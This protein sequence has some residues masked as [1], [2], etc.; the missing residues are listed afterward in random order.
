MRQDP[1]GATL[2]GI[3]DYDTLLP[4]D[5]PIGFLERSAWLRDFDQRLVA[6]VPWEELPTEH[7]VDFALLRSKL[8]FRRAEIEEI[9]THQKNPALY[10]ETALR[11]VFLLLARPFAP[12]EERKEPVLARLMALPEYLDAA[13]ANLQRVPAV[14]RDIAS[15]V[16]TGGLQFVDEVLRT[17]TRSFPGEAERIEHAGARARV[18]LIRYQEFLDRD[19]TGKIGGS[20]AIGER[21]MNYRLE[22]E[23]LLSMDCAYLEQ[24]GRDSMDHI[25]GQLVEEA[26]R[27]EPE[28]DW[29]ELVGNA[30]RRHP[31]ALRVRDAYVSEMERARRFVQEKR[32][33]PFAEG[34]L[35]IVD[36]PAFERATIPIASYLPPAPFD[37]EQAGTFFVTPIDLSRRREDVDSMLHSHNYCAITLASLH[38]AYPGHHLQFTHAAH[39]G[40]RLRR[41]ADSPVMAEGWALYCE[42]MMYEQGFFLDPLTRLYQLRDL[43]WRACRVVIDVGLHS[44][45]MS[46][47]QAVDFL[48][49]NAL[50]ER[51]SA[52]TEVKRYALTPTVPLSFLVGRAMLLDLREEAKRRL[53]SRFVLHDFHAQ[54]LRSGTVPPFFVREELFERLGA[55]L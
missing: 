29:R 38:E 50:L 25:R 28:R 10:P 15:E 7:R 30:K 22:H 40:S 11:G 13:R 33:A 1:V 6:S 3:H 23:H 26:R 4:N 35:E 47:E 31:E 44:G 48:V 21:W 12:L 5:T 49:E 45:R 52:E 27:I 2:V 43:L 19:L 54:I 20:V 9:R 34:R 18:G 14:M 55:G 16:T 17:L 42:E 51:V 8:S 39:S 37:V 24:F 53:G 32:I 46:S 41:L 36:T